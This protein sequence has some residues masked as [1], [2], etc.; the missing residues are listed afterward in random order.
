M[1]ITLKGGTQINYVAPNVQ[2]MVDDISPY[3]MKYNDAN[4]NARMTYNWKRPAETSWLSGIL[5][6]VVTFVLFGVFWWF[7]MKHMNSALGDAGKQMNF[8]KA[9]IKQNTDEKR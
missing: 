6:I 8:G 2:Q 9:K 3:V 4:P 5:P 1:S 7:M